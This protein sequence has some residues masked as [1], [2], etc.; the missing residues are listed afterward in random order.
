MPSQQTELGACFHRGDRGG[1]SIHP[2]S[3]FFCCW[4]LLFHR[5]RNR[6]Q[7]PVKFIATLGPGSG[8]DFGTRLLGDRLS[9]R[10]GQ[11]VVIEN[12]PG[13]DAVVAVSA[14]ISANDDHVLLASPTSALTAHPYV[15]QQ[16]PYKDSDLLPIARGWNTVIVIA[17]PAA[18]AVT[19]MHDLVAMTRANPGHSTG[20]AR[21]APSISSSR[22]FSRKTIST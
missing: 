4:F 15:L 5:R 3:H 20:P 12:R 6:P 7:R 16:M 11:P 9:K 22:G 8:V 18:M 17:V 1:D 19:T 21:P 10:W 2:P 14:V 13:G